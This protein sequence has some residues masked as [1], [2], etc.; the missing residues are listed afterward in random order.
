M[1]S[2][3]S[4]GVADIDR[5]L[6]FYDAV[7]GALGYEGVMPVDIPGLGR[8]GMGYGKPGGPPD[9]WVQYPIDQKPA[10]AGNGSHFAF[11]AQTKEAVHAFHAAG[12]E[13]GGADAGPPGPRPMYSPDYYAAYLHD[14][15]GNKVEAC[16]T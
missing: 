1:L 7:L 13:A 2:H 11:I 14:P 4:V 15:D 5:A 8:V 12:L 16:L 6:R 10:S 9:F 3:V